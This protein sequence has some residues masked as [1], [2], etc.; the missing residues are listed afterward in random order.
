VRELIVRFK[1]NGDLA[2]GR[3]LAHLLAQHIASMHP[4]QTT[5]TLLV[6]VPL[7][8][9][10]LRER[11]FNQAQ[12]IARILSLRLGIPVANHAIRRVLRTPDQKQLSAEAR[13]ANLRGAFEAS[14]VCKGQDVAVVDDVVTTGATADA[15]AG[16]LLGAGAAEVRIWCLARAT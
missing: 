15:I 5:P 12:R 4:P 13:K 9:R 2:A 3:V 10:R 8:P 1:F 11:G 14:A 6:P 7:H 16:A